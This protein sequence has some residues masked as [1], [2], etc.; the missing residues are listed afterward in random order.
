MMI[1]SYNIYFGVFH[2]VC[3][4]KNKFSYESWKEY[5]EIIEDEQ[6]QFWIVKRIPETIED[7]YQDQEV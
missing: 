5:P 3:K 4:N 1:Q 2:Y 6:I 7:E